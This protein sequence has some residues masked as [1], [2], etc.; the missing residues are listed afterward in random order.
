M[1]Y[2]FLIFFIFLVTNFFSQKDSLL[3]KPGSHA[4]SFILS[5]QENTIQSFTMPYMRRIILL[6]FWSTSVKKSRTANKYLSRL[7]ERY[8][9]VESTIE[10][11]KKM[12]K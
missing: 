1:K 9:I 11:L 6:H 10:E 8:K 12:V 4:P 3:L 7:A 5:L 2:K